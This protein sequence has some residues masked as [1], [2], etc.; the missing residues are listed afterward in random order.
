MVYVF[1]LKI[2]ICTQEL[3]N[4][5]ILWF[6]SIVCSKEAT[7]FETPGSHVCFAMTKSFIEVSLVT[8]FAVN[9]LAVNIVK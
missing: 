6:C 1:K 2:N 5:D 7:F 4:D 9:S 8:C 3:K